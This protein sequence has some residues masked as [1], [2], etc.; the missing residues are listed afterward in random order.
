MVIEEHAVAAWPAAVGERADGWLLRHT[1]GV[2][3]R[4]CNSALPLEPGAE[5]TLERV[6][7]FYTARGM[8]PTVQIAPAERLADLD[9]TLAAAGYHRHGET[10]V[11]RAPTAVVVVAAAGEAVRVEL[12]ERPTERWLAAFEELDDHADSAAVAEGVIARIA[13]PAAFA[14]VTL[15]GRVAGMGLLVGGGAWGGVFSMATRPAYR[16]RGVASAILHALAT[17]AADHGTEDLYLQ[18][19]RENDTARRLYERMGFTHSHSYH[20]RSANPA[21]P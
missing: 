14:S 6:T 5:R 16:R 10:L 20:Y 17:W 4:R 11:L 12:D 21:R 1:P 15:D 7:A 3:R 13:L 18:V 2:S 19:E 8:A 9:D